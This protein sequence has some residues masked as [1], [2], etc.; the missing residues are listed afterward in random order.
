MVREFDPTRDAAALRTCLIEQQDYHRNFEPSWP[1]GDAIVEEY[2]VYLDKECA[3]HN[4]RIFIAE[5]EEQPAGFV[6]V[7]AAMHGDSPE[8]PAPFAWIHEIYVKQEYRRRGVAGALMAEAE[9]FVRS[10]GAQ[11]LR[12]SV[13]AQ[14]AHARTLY[15]SRGFGEYA[16]VLTKALE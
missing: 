8:D 14:N 5:H 10:Q 11:R 3:L 4:G 1:S 2:I 7:V 12:L 6:C 13:L 16:H 15:A 9:R